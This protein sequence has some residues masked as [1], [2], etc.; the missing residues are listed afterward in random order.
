MFDCRCYWRWACLPRRQ[1]RNGVEQAMVDAM[2][3][4]RLAEDNRDSYPLDVTV[5]FVLVSLILLVVHVFRS[6]IPRSRW[7]H[8]GH[9]RGGQVLLGYSALP[10]AISCGAVAG[11][12]IVDLIF[13]PARPVIPW[14]Y[15]PFLVVFVVCSAW[16]Y[17]EFER[18]TLRRTRP[19]SARR[20]SV[21]W[22]C[23]KLCTGSDVGDR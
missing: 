15:L 3:Y 13:R 5:E 9:M 14:P 20:W 23:G 4:S 11:I 22:N 6:G 19:G 12:G 18:P 21:I 17:K 7:Q 2:L 16:S 10:A 8:S 1:R